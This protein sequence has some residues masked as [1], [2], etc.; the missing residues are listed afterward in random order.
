M[1][2]LPTHDRIAREPRDPFA[3]SIARPGSEYHIKSSDQHTPADLDP[4][5]SR[6]TDEQFSARIVTLDAVANAMRERLTNGHLLIGL[7]AAA[8]IGV[9]CVATTLGAVTRIPAI[10]Q[11][12]AYDARV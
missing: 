5:V 2:S 12:L 8:M 3:W 10:E 1:Q 4:H 6:I 11:Q 9:I 7:F